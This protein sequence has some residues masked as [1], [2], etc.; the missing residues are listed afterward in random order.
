[1][2]FPAFEPINLKNTL[3]LNDIALHHVSP[4]PNQPRKFF[5]EEALRELAE[6]IK[7]YGVIQPIIVRE[8]SSEKYLIIAGERRWRASQSAGLKSIPAVIKTDKHEDNAAVSLVENIQREEL[9]PIELAQAYLKLSRDHSLSHD[10]ISKMVGKSRAAIS[11]T[12]R[13]L[14][15][16]ENI[17]KYLIDGKLEVGHARS[18]LTLSHEKQQEIAKIIISENLTVR[19]AERVIRNLQKNNNIDQK[20]FNPYVHEIKHLESGLANIFNTD[21]VIKVHNNGSAHCSIHFSSI[22]AVENFLEKI[23]EI[24]KV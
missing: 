19:D 15:L 21:V 23:N 4:D 5:S 12:M 10:E 6:S 24:E 20:H 7:K 14:N 2:K 16:S 3:G 1:M 9:N 18:I 13:L 11:N 22:K 8:I 17:M